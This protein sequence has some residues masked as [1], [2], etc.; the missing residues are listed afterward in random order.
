[1]SHDSLNNNNIQGFPN[2]ANKLIGIKQKI[3]QDDE[4]LLRIR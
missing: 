2:L 1:M 4:R 3:N